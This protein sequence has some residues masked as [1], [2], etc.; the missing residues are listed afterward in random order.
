MCDIT[1]RISLGGFQFH[2][3]LAMA[4]CDRMAPLSD[5]TQTA[6]LQMFSRMVFSLL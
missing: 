2:S 1:F 4:A 3:N 6:V 5:K